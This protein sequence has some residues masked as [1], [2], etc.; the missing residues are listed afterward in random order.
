MCLKVHFQCSLLS[1]A[2]LFCALWNSFVHTGLQKLGQAA[3]STAEEARNVG[4][5]SKNVLSP[6]LAK[7][8][9]TIENKYYSADVHFAVHPMRGLAP[10]LLQNVPAVI[11]VW[12]SNEVSHSF[13]LCCHDI[14]L[15]LSSYMHHFQA[16]K[17]HIERLSHDLNGQEPEVS[18]AVRVKSLPDEVPAEPM[19]AEESREDNA[20]I[21][22]FVSGFGF[23]Y[24]DA[25][26]DV[27]DQRGERQYKEEDGSDSELLMFLPLNIQCQS[28]EPPDYRHSK[29]SSCSRCLEYGHVA[30][31]ESTR[32]RHKIWEGTS[33]T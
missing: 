32:E 25:T 6:D 7:I 3:A 10:Y 33:A 22:G 2:V 28:T 17:H 4:E 20:A 31:D 14:R 29:P 27:A 26:R 19:D 30:V 13:N 9:W 8:P 23:E 16:Y 1:W 12:G 5:G 24:I 15:S 18:L 21:D 11:F